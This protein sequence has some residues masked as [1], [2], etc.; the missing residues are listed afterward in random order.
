MMRKRTPNGIMTA[1][2]AV[3][4]IVW[5]ADGG[6]DDMRSSLLSR[7]R[8]FQAE[9]RNST[10]GLP[11]R[12]ESEA[13]DNLQRAEITAVIPRDFSELSAA[14]ARPADWCDIA[15]LVFNIKAC[16]HQR[17][18]GQEQLNLYVGRKFYEPPEKAYPFKY[19]FTLGA[20]RDDYLLVTLEAK[21]G[22]F[23]TGDYL[24]EIEAA[25][26]D[27]KTF[28]AFRSSCRTS[29]ISNLA[30]RIYLATAGRHKVGFSLVKSDGQSIEPVRGIRGIIERNA[31][32]FYL[33]LQAHLEMHALAPDK[34]YEAALERWHALTEQYH[35]QLYEMDKNEYLATKRRERLN[36]VR[37]QRKIDDTEQGLAGGKGQEL[38]LLPGLR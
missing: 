30:T 23:G 38:T 34:R 36:Q 32:R 3:C 6:A 37:L 14:L 12:I 26:I 16:T 18:R 17:S 20:R 4:L 13:R 15:P 7:Y 31:V 24:L 29:M 35:R 5:A 33:A 1:M 22:P 21:E 19:L 2:L 10:A 28:L 11:I 27:G 25:G 9:A 8:Q